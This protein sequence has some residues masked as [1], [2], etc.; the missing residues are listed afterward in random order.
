MAIDGQKLWK[1]VKAGAKKWGI[2][3]GVGLSILAATQ[4]MELFW[5]EDWQDAFISKG[6]HPSFW[7]RA[8]KVLVGVFGGVGEIL[9]LSLFFGIFFDYRERSHLIDEAAQSIGFRGDLK[10]MGVIDFKEDSK[11]YDH[12]EEFSGSDRLVICIYGSSAFFADKMELIKKRLRAGKN[13]EIVLHKT[14][15]GE[16][17]LLLGFLKAVEIDLGHVKISTHECNLRYNF[18]EVDDGMWIKK[19]FLNPKGLDYGTPGFF[20][21][22][23]SP[24]W[25]KYQHDIGLLKRTTLTAQDVAALV[26]A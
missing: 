17:K 1:A 20:V 18:I 4:A 12:A 23:D 16:V 7:F 11:A 8:T 21:K 15:V 5:L 2:L 6:M 24:L 13:I 26:P 14:K 22:K 9:I 19:Y 25:E 10:A 3:F